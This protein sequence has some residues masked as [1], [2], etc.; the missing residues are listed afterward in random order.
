MR[1]QRSVW[2]A[3][4]AIIL[5]LLRD[6][7]DERWTRAE[8]VAEISDLRPKAV[9]AALARLEAERVIVTWGGY[10]LAARCAWHLDALELVS[11]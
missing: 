3:Q 1:P 9:T 8:L 7:H 4:R 11:I 2:M 10:F 5:Q 6:D